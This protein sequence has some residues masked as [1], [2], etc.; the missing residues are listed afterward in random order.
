MDESRPLKRHAGD[1]SHSPPV[2]CKR[3]RLCPLPAKQAPSVVDLIQG[4]LDGIL[5]LLRKASSA[6][7]PTD[8]ALSPLSSDE[9]E[10]VIAQDTR[11]SAY[12]SLVRYIL[13]TF[14]S[15]FSP[16]A[17]SLPMSAF[18]MESQASDSS[19]LPKLVLS[20][21]AK[22]AFS[23]IDGW[24]AEKREQ[25]RAIFSF[26]PTRL[27]KRKQLPYATGGSS[28]SGSFCLL[29][30]RLLRADRFLL[31]ICFCIS[32]DYVQFDGTLRSSQKLTP[33]L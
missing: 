29:P 8:L 26:P 27:P 25:G 22:K 11:P 33:G 7:Q 23:D 15:F 30:G 31:Q 3:F 32:R 13:A 5:G 24:L 1:V 4:K 20:S 21:F 10:A 18:L 6:P 12:A 14:P 2:P 28:C 16:A 19:R 9:K 17:P